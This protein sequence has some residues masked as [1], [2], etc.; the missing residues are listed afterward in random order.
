MW[1]TTDSD[2]TKPKAGIWSFTDGLGSRLFLGTSGSYATGIT[3]SALTVN[4]NGNIGIASTTPGYRLTVESSGG[5][6]GYFNNPVFVGT[7]TSPS[8]AATKAYVDTAA[9]NLSELTVSGTSTL[10]GTTTVNG[11]WQL[12]GA[13]L[14]NINMNG[15][16]IVGI[17]KLTVSTIDPVYEIAGKKY[18]TY[19]SDT[20]G[21]KMEAY[22]KVLASPNGKGYSAT[23]DFGRA[24][25]GSDLWLFW[26]TVKEGK[27]MQDVVLTLSPEGTDA[28]VWYDL[29]PEEKQ[30]V[31]Y[32]NK[33]AKVSYHLVAPRH[34]AEAWPTILKK[35]E[36]K[37][38]LLP[39]R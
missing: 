2:S 16:N 26:H 37:G 9:G 21:L 7:P 15:Y 38:V 10:N 29:R 18:A 32:A 14:G 5:S 23:L 22:G 1:Y 3:N 24:A 4:W 20:I 36:E 12:A 30:I 11:N 31:I 19:V 28:R 39:L 25:V 34:D 35:S 13:A 17:N 6:A 8:H 27:Y 33:S